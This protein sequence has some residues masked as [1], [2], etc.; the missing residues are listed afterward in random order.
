MLPSKNLV[1]D[2][3]GTLANYENLPMAWADYY[4]TVFES[5]NNVLKIPA[6]PKQIAQ[7]F[8][9][10]LSQTAFLKLHVSLTVLHLKFAL[11]AMKKKMS[12]QLKPQAGMQS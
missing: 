10:N 8:Y 11:L 4:P 7:S 6:A 9:K 3:G 5:V 2:F 12:K 1:F